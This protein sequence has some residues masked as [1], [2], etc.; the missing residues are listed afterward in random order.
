M[1]Y[2]DQG[3]LKRTTQPKSLPPPKKQISHHSLLWTQRVSCIP[4]MI[5]LRHCNAPGEWS[6]PS[7]QSYLSNILA[8]IMVKKL[9][10]SVCFVKQR[11]PLSPNAM[12]ITVILLEGL[13]GPQNW[14][15]GDE[16]RN[17]VIKTKSLLPI[18]LCHAP[19]YWVHAV[20]MNCIRCSNSFFFH[21]C[22]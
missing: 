14:S 12:F 10:H 22:S 9:A 6:L 11:W 18:R 16:E 13:P 15:T 1:R 3:I 19:C 2:I 17:I 7:V 21:E 8:T 20:V 4:Y 5:S